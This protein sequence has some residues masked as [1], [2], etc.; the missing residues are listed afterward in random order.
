[1]FK[2][3]L[4]IFGISFFIS[5]Q[6]FAEEA[7]PGAEAFP[8]YYGSAT[9]DHS[10]FDIILRGVVLPK[11]SI[12]AMIESLK[13]KLGSRIKPS[14][15]IP[16]GYDINY[17][18]YSILKED[19]QIFI[20]ANK[21]YIQD[22]KQINPSKLSKPEQLAYWLNLRNALVLD[23]FFEAYPVKPKRLQTIIQGE[24]WTTPMVLINGTP[25]SIKDIEDLVI[26]VWPDPR[27]LYGF[28]YGTHDSPFIMNVAFTGD[29]V[30][31]LLEKNARAYL[32][33]SGTFKFSR[34]GVV[35]PGVFEWH[36]AVFK[37]D[38][39]VLKAH[40]SSYLNGRQLGKFSKTASA[41][42]SFKTNWK[43]NE[44]PRQFIGTGENRLY[45]YGVGIGC[46]GIQ[47][48]EGCDAGAI[49]EFNAFHAHIISRQK[50]KF[51][52]N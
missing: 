49:P 18:P 33:A 50:Q 28:F 36:K 2:T 12:V 7:N 27:V 6:A 52:L 35:V 29:N 13:P 14:T 30:L 47:T 26:R 4:F 34:S 17:V 11:E 1:M 41:G 38:Q 15:T 31:G 51:G 3:L 42:L 40:L 5:T 37:G 39:N 9:Y 46:T 20:T 21:F 10:Y 45:V 22:L 24:A 8:V 44:I 48:S 16:K 23:L 43:L 32:N 25:F 19:F